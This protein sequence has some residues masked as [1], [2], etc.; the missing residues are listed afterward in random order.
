VPNNSPL[1]GLHGDHCAGNSPGKDRAAKPIRRIATGHG[2]EGRSIIIADG[3]APKVMMQATKTTLT[4]LWEMTQTP[5]SNADAE[6]ASLRPVHLMPPKNGSIFRIVEFS[7]DSDRFPT[8][9][10]V[11]ASDALDS[12][13][14]RLVRP[15]GIVVRCYCLA[16]RYGHLARY[17]MVIP[18]LAVRQRGDVPS[19][20]GTA[21]QWPAR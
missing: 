12:D 21:R 4:D 16:F 5:A 3:P 9:T 1:R 20:R 7:P 11:G 14:S 2:A 6:D 15:F 10:A 13:G 19:W 17:L 18:R 8:F